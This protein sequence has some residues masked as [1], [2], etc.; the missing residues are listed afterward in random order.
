MHPYRT[1]LALRHKIGVGWACSGALDGFFAYDLPTGTV[2][3]YPAPRRARVKRHDVDD[4]LVVLFLAPAVG[5][6]WDPRVTGKMI[7]DVDCNYRGY[8]GVVD[9]HVGNIRTDVPV[10]LVDEVDGTSA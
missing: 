6:N 3:G 1:G 8:R 7:S 9:D 5:V 4:S 2:F 10:H